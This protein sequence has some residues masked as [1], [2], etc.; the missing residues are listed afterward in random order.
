MISFL[1][2]EDMLIQL[3]QL[4]LRNE[5]N[6]CYSNATLCWLWWSIL[7]RNGYQYGDWGSSRDTMQRFFCQL[8]DRRHSLS[9]H[10]QALFTLWA[11]GTLPAD[12]AEFAYYALSWMDT[13]CISHRWGRFYM[14]QNERHQHDLG[15][16]HAPIFLQVPN[17]SIT[18]ICLQDLISRWT[19]HYGMQTALLDA[20][21]VLLC[22]VDRNATHFNG[23]VTKLDFWL[24]ADHVC[25]FPS[26]Q[27]DGSQV[28]HDYVPVS[29]LAHL[30]DLQGGHYR[31]ALRLT[32]GE[33]LPALQT[34]DTLWALT[35]DHQ[36][37]EIY[38]LPGM[39]DWL[40]RNLT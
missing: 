22:H 31:A 28:H 1:D 23:S 29:M 15:D 30:G 36:I 24:H 13:S 3:T 39:P 33:H 34:Q 38:Q 16:V 8:S 32:G 40:C 9:D 21:D 4:R 17:H 19:Q 5:A 10:F 25:S 37:P 35:D 2:R 20:P 12:A 27:S 6:Y 26:F 7:S 11:H 18:T 14:S